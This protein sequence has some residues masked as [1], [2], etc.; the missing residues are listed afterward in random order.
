MASPSQ[1]VQTVSDVTH[2]PIATIADYDRKL[3]KD[4]LRTRGGRGLHAAQMTP[5]DA[6]RL[7]TAVL[8]S[9]QA[10][11]AAFTVRRYA[12][13]EVDERVSTRKNFKLTGIDDLA[14]L[15]PKH[16]FVDGL[17][18]LITSISGGTLREVGLKS[19]GK[20]KPQIE[21]YA[22]T[23]ATR[24]AIRLGAMPPGEAVTV[25]YGLPWGPKRDQ[26]QRYAGEPSDS[27]RQ[28]GDLEQTR[29]VSAATIVSIAR[30]LAGDSNE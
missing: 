11:A 20:W 14:S 8:A 27:N 24:G 1:L 3:V 30:L 2:I 5:L 17:S 25:E 13:T 9:P 18:A 22:S 23:F 12:R 4:S 7:L 15:S 26:P 21:V 6:A 10:N 16:S 19:R 29:R 28:L